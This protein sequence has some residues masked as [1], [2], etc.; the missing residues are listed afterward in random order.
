MSVRVRGKVL[1]R[2][3]VFACI[4]FLGTLS[5][6]S[7]RAQSPFGTELNQGTQAHREGNYEE[8]IGHFQ[9]AVSLNP[10]NRVAHLYL[11]TAL[12]GRTVHP[13]S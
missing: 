9:K 3:Y 1:K 12:A 8:A 13:W 4:A 7:L 2:K 11:A 6:V 10:Q 5:S